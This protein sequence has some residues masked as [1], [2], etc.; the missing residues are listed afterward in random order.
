M[1]LNEKHWTCIGSLAVLALSAG[2]TG[3]LISGVAEAP[4][5][6]APRKVDSFDAERYGTLAKGLVRPPLWQDSD[7][8]LFIS[9]R[10]AF[11]PDDGTIKPLRSDILDPAGIPIAWKEK[12]GFPIDDPQVATMDPDQDGFSNLEEFQA[13]TDPTNPKSS[14]PPI[15]KLRLVDYTPVFFVMMF[16]GYVVN[17]AGVYTFQINFPGGRTALVEE[18]AILDE[19]GNKLQS[20]AKGWKVSKF[21]L[22]KETRF[23]EKTGG[24]REFDE[25]ELELL[26]PT[27]PG[28]VVTLV[29]N[30]RKELDES[31]ASFQALIPGAARLGPISPGQIFEFAGK[32]Y[33]LVRTTRDEAIIR[34]TPS[35]KEIAIQ[36]LAPG[37]ETPP[38]N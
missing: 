3:W 37:G 27:L 10:L 12:F 13:E 23:D 26:H 31:R 14:P 29:L 11:F 7:H 5:L 22:K 25:S 9:R 2:L 21:N 4:S 15:Q 34:E 35:G 33:Q 28:S 17:E 18:G 19:R 16:K 8:A 32:S 24:Q 36:R 38:S 6:G 30:K 1:A 20:G